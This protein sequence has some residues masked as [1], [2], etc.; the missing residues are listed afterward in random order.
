[1]PTNRHRRAQ[2]LA[3]EALIDLYELD[4][5]KYGGGVRYWTAGPMG[6]GALNAIWNPTLKTSAAGWGGDGLWSN[7]GPASTITP[8]EAIPEGNGVARWSTG[9]PAGQGR[10]LYW[11]GRIRCHPGNWV[12]ASIKVMTLRCQ[13][14]VGVQWFDASNASISVSWSELVAFEGERTISLI[15]DG[16]ILSSSPIPIDGSILDANYQTAFVEAQAPSG[17]V[18]AAFVM[19]IYPIGGGGASDPYLWMTQAMF[20]ATPQQIGRPLVFGF[21]A[22]VGMVSFDGQAYQPIPVRVEGLQRAGRGP[23]PRIS[24]AIPD[25]DN[26]ASALLA[27]YKDLLG[28]KITRKQVFRSALDDGAN[29]DPSDFYGPEI[30]FIDR[31]SRHVPGVEVVLECASPLDIQGTLIPGRQM[32]RDVCDFSYRSWNGASFDYGGCPYTGSSYFTEDNTSTAN[33]ALDRCSKGLGG[34]RARFGTTAVLP[35]RGFPGMGRSRV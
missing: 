4:A 7:F 6:E 17:T 27:T 13:M 34:C 12:Q 33:P 19:E 23:V 16:E 14:R 22:K 18:E 8:T 11:N 3:S 24:L 9:I 20:A 30:Y 25:I 10:T 29:A 26:M 1:M 2:E 31:V 35:F 32:I 21:G 5:S 15:E 28:C